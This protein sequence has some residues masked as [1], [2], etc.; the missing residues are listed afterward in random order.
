MPSQR[1]SPGILQALHDEG[2]DLFLHQQGLDTSTT[3]GKA[4]FQMLGVFAEFERGIIRERVMAGLS[5]A[6]SPRPMPGRLALRER[7]GRC[8]STARPGSPARWP[9]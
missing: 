8:N 3:A 4:M 5:R 9:E 6:N 2:V 1:S 7:Q